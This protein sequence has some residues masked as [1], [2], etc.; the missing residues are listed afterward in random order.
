MIFCFL[1]KYEFIIVLYMDNCS[2]ILTQCTAYYSNCRL[3]TCYWIRL[4]NITL[5]TYWLFF[6]YIY[7]FIFYVRFV[8]YV[9]KKPVGTW[10][11]C[12]SVSRLRLRSYVK[13]QSQHDRYKLYY[14]N[15]V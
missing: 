13:F 1:H 6:F 15:G 7:L 14:L 2:D 4:G 5:I 9:Q 11:V 3:V 12:F 8:N 10:R